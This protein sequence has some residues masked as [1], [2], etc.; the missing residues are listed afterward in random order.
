[1]PAESCRSKSPFT[2][3]ASLFQMVI[4]VFGMG[5]TGI[6]RDRQDVQDRGP[7]KRPCI[8]R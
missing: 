5:F 2:S 7:V 1:M 8:R 6:H 4:R 3:M